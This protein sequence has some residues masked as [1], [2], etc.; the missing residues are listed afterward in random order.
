M[1]ELIAWTKEAI[2][3]KSLHPL[4]ITSVFIVTFLAIHP[5]QDGNG[6]LS[7]ALTTYLLLSFGY[8]YIPYSSL[9][10]V[11]EN[12]KE[13]YY[14]ALRQIQGTLKAEKPNWQPWLLLF[15]NLI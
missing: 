10:P 5:F 15:L 1:E 3:K 14:L 11:I 4:L 8:A 12:S 7:R 13:G 9:G 6:R 2:G